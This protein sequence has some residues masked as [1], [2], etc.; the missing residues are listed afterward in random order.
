MAEYSEVA[1]DPEFKSRKEMD[2]HK[3]NAKVYLVTSIQAAVS[4]GSAILDVYRSSEFEIEE[5]AVQFYTQAAGK[6]N[7]L[8]EVSRALLRIAKRRA[9]H[10]EQLDAIT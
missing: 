6:L 8:P 4:A 1:L 5:K 7:G 10:K 3:M 2:H 9:Q